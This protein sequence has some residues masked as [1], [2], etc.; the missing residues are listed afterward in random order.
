MAESHED[1]GDV[2]ERGGQYTGPAAHVT[3]AANDPHDDPAYITRTKFLSGVAVAGGAVMGAAILVPVVGF[4]VA[5]T[6]KPEKWRWVDVGPLSDF[7]NGEVT[8]IAFNGPDPEA[9]RRAFIRHKDNTIIAIWSRCAHLGCPTQYSKGGDS[10]TCPCH[11]G[12]YDALRRVTG[13]PP[14]RPLDRF[15]VKIVTPDGK[16]VALTTSPAEGVSTAK[17]KPEDRVLVGIAF[18]ID[19]NQNPYRLHG[20]GEAVNGMLANLY[21]F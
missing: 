17:A 9:D 12:A 19:E 8:S 20:P 11:G 2:N 13:G 21:P 5:D 7:P 14:P 4:A 18:S 16:D 6:V 1:G 15:D 10:F 3:D